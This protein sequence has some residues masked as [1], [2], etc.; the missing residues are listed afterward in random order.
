[1]L[2]PTYEPSYKL[3]F[4]KMWL[5]HIFATR[6]RPVMLWLGVNSDFW[7]KLQTEIQKDLKFGD[8]DGP[9]LCRVK[10]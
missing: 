5:S 3:W 9:N 2:A 4:K 10:K 7:T 1:M 8:G 6:V